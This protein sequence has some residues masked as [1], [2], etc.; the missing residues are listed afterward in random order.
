MYIFPPS[1]HFLQL[2]INSV[3][4][5]CQAS[6]FEKLS[7]QKSL[8]LAGDGRADSPGQS[9]KY[10]S[11]AV[12]ERSLNKV[13]NFKVVQVCMFINMIVFCGTAFLT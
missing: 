13:L 3:W 11:Y 12:I 5:K 8:I 10:G 1:K 9:A 4:Q 2:A 6:L 7:Q